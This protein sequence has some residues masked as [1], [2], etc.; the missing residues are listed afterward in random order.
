[1]G[2][3]L[4]R[5]VIARR[6]PPHRGSVILTDSSLRWLAA[7]VGPWMAARLHRSRAEIIQEIRIRRRLADL[8]S[9]A[10]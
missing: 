2:K 3:K 1:M 8:R 9:L 6:D 7:K 5:E 10:R 4:G